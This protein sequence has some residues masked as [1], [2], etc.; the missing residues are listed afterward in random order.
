MSTCS[1]INKTIDEIRSDLSKG[2]NPLNELKTTSSTTEIYQGLKNIRNMF[3]TDFVNNDDLKSYKRSKL[4]LDPSGR[5]ARYV[6]SD[7]GKLAFQYRTTDQN[8]I[9]FAEKKGEIKANEISKQPDNK[10]KAEYGTAIHN[11]AQGLLEDEIQNYLKDSSIT[12]KVQILSANDQ[13][14]SAYQDARKQFNSKQIEDVRKEVRNIL[15]SIIEKQKSINAKTGNNDPV[16]ILTE[17]FIFSKSGNNQDLGCTIDLMAIYSDKTTSIWDYKSITPNVAKLDQKGNIK[18][19]N[20]IPYYKL[21]DINR[22]MSTIKELVENELGLKINSIRAV[23]I[24]MDFELDFKKPYGEQIKKLK[25]FKIGSSMNKY[26][27]QIPII[28][29][30][31]GISKFD[32]A[33]EKLILMKR[34]L[35]LELND[36][37]EGSPKAYITQNKISQ[38]QD[39]INALQVNKDID[40]VYK[41][42]KELVDKYLE[43]ESTL[44]DI[45]N[46]K[47]EVENEDGSLITTYNKNY[48]DIEGINSLKEELNILSSIMQSS[49]IF[50]NALDIKD[51]DQKADIEAKLREQRTYIG[52]T[53]I[54]IDLLNE[55]LESRL[56]TEEEIEKSKSDKALQLGDS[57]FRRTSEQQNSVIQK[58]YKSISLKQDAKRLKIQTLESQIKEKQLALEKWAKQNGYKGFSIY[59]RLINNKTGNLY[60]KTK[61]ELWND[62]KTLKNSSRTDTNKN[63][64]LKFYKLKD[65]YKEIYENKQ[66]SYL[67]KNGNLD[68]FEKEW[69]LTSNNVIFDNIKT[70]Y[71]LDFDKIEKDM[72][73]YITEEYKE[74]AKI[75]PLKEYYDFY[76]STMSKLNYIADVDQPNTFIANIRKDTV[77]KFSNGVYTGFQQIGADYIKEFKDVFKYNALDRNDFSN[78]QIDPETKEVKNTI[79]KMFINPL[80]NNDGEVDNSLKS[81][82]LS[83]SLI[84]YADMAY[85]YQAMDQLEDEIL[86]IID[87]VKN[88]NS[89]IGKVDSEATGVTTRILR[90]G[91]QTNNVGEYL[92]KMLDYYVY[93]IENQD[94]NKVDNK[95]YDGAMYVMQKLDTLHKKALFTFNLKT[96]VKAVMATKVL[97]STEAAKGIYFDN[98]MLTRTKKDM[99]SA[100]TKIGGSKLSE[101]PKLE[102]ILYYDLLKFFDVYTDKWSPER[103]KDLSAKKINLG[104]A[105]LL[106]LGDAHIDNTITY[107]LLQNYGIY[108]GKLYRLNKPGTPKNIKSLLES[109]SN[110]DGKLFIEGLMD[111]DFNVNVELYNDFRR[112]AKNVSI[113]QKGAIS[114]EDI[115][116]VNMTQAGKLIMSLKNWIPALMTERINGIEY[117]YSTK[118]ITIGRY[119]SLFNELVA[120]KEMREAYKN[121]TPDQK[122]N[123]NKSDYLLTHRVPHL[124]TNVVLKGLMY[125]YAYMGASVANRLGANIDVNTNKFLNMAGAV[126]EERAKIIL[127]NYKSKYPTNQDIQNITLEEFMEY[128][129]GQIRAV[130]LELTFILTLALVAGLIAADDDDDEEMNWLQL[131]S[132]RNTRLM[133]RELS[134]FINP[135]DWTDSVKVI[136]PAINVMQRILALMGKT[137]DQT[138][139]LIFEGEINP[140]ETPFYE[141][142]IKMIPYFNGIYD[143]FVPNIEYLKN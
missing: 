69:G 81:F 35:I 113:A 27:S 112:I 20:W 17:Q 33:I 41:M 55:T 54:L 6:F 124:L 92:Q 118:E 122:D 23:P 49:S 132:Y 74:I 77:E 61:P 76:S 66:K 15:I 60:S 89:E 47:L 44:V 95:V 99:L 90:K 29:E 136:T 102:G 5:T 103:M 133:V 100:L 62:I 110:K 52:R 98:K 101:N 51:K 37:P 25:G 139:D 119:R 26:L 83:K 46:F 75:K 10:I 135:T 126:S 91:G 121:M 28:Q 22:Q 87:L 68:N 1:I 97:I 111:K 39:K 106:G 108:Q 109:A 71:E 11:L 129:V 140:R 80:Y 143:T 70:Y 65:N 18:D 16:A 13:D 134:F 9:K 128:N 2:I 94:L 21:D 24:Q 85:N 31:T 34:N 48:L 82:D 40:S 63:K 117:N 38:I 131:Q 120:P 12:D 57:I 32:D 116:Q 93:G 115:N 45:D 84:L 88:D 96:V 4:H 42:Y 3:K 59:E 123:I 137:V 36:I 78:K 50:Y 142:A 64:L 138:S 43:T 79:P 72:S 73:H 19:S 86:A 104:Y 30:V 67:L 130:A 8:K 53:Q 56:F 7:T 107:T 141:S 14:P 114:K 58:V 125:S 127:E 105:N